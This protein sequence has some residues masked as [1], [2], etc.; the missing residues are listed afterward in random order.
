M[1][2]ITQLLGDRATPLVLTAK[3][4]QKFAPLL[5]SS[6][7]DGLQKHKIQK[8]YWKLR[9]NFYWIFYSNIY[10]Q[11]VLNQAGDIP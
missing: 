11:P 3:T 10:H 2:Q 6:Q 9:N 1:L 5:A 7:H 8:R 4:K